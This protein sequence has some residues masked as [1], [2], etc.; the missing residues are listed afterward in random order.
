M[1]HLPARTYRRV[2]RALILGTEGPA[3]MRPN[4][5]S[6]TRHRVLVLG[7]WHGN[8]VTARRSEALLFIHLNEYPMYENM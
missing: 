6:T 3:T 2:M 7:D 4:A 1:G 5:T 8:C